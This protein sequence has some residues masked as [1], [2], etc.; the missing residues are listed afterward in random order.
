MSAGVL[1]ADH[2]ERGRLYAA[3]DPAV[4]HVEP[5]VRSTRFGAWLAP[6]SSHE[7]AERALIDAGAVIGGG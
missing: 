2:D 3:W 4:R 1:S 5:G 6:Y 7:E